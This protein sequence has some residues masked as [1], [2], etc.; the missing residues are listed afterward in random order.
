MSTDTIHIALGFDQNYVMPCG[1]TIVSICENTPCDI[2]FHAIIAEDVSDENK[3][4]IESVVKKYSKKITFYT[5]EGTQFDQL[6]ANAHISRSTYNRFLIPDL[7]SSDIKKVLYVDT[8]IVAVKSLVSLWET[9]LLDNEPAAMAIDARCSGVKEHNAIDIPLSQPYYNAG[10]LLMNLEC[11]RKENISRQ[12]IDKIVEHNYPWM[13]QDALNVVI[14]NR[15]KKL[16]VRYNLQTPFMVE[17]ESDWEVERSLY[18]DE[19]FMGKENPVILHYS[20]GRKPWQ[21]GCNYSGIWLQCKNISP[22]KHESLLKD[23]YAITRS[24]YELE[25]AERLD[26]DKLDLYAPGYLLLFQ[27]SLQKHRWIIWTLNKFFWFVIRII[28]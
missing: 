10:I 25:K 1:I 3:Q 26:K 12:C 16:H 21:N 8:D 4:K 15:V 2:H 5:I 14:G 24:R 20:Q 17:P 19:I 23:P 11:W 6:P 7:L 27:Y 9:E 13:D 18:F 28:K 22:W